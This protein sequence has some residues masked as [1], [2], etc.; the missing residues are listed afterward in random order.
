VSQMRGQVAFFLNGK[1]HQV[2]GSTCFL[3]LSDYLRREN[4]L[5]GTKVVCAEG[6]CGAC[7]VLK[8]SPVFLATPKPHFEMVNS[9]IALVAQ[10]DGCVLLTVEALGEL[11]NL[12]P[13]Q[14]AM[15]ESHASQCGFCTPGFVVAMVDM[16]E[17][18]KG[19]CSEQE[20][21]NHL[22]GNLCRCTGYQSIIEAAKSQ[23]SD[24]Y[25][26]LRKKYL[27]KTVVE[28]LTKFCRKAL[29]VE[30]QE[31]V[32]LAP[33]SKSELISVI[34]KHPKAVMIAAGTDLG[35]QRNKH[36]RRP[37]VLISLHLIKE[38]YETKFLKDKV[39]VSARVTFSELR[40]SLLKKCPTVANFLDVFASPQIKN[41]ATLVGNVANGSPIADAPPFLFALNARIKVLSSKTEKL[42]EIP[43]VDFYLDYRKLKLKTGELIW[44]VS[45]DLPSKNE[46]LYLQKITQ[47]KDLD[48][49]CVNVGFWSKKSSKAK[50]SD[51]RLALGGVAATP[52]RLQKTEK[53][54]L[55]NQ[56]LEEA[57]KIA[58]S[59]IS[60]L[61]DLR[62][63]SAYRR[64]VVHNYLKDFLSKQV[65]L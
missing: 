1:L 28:T 9:C 32:L 23:S 61:S 49:S 33:C 55:K 64:L 30:S 27:G 14:K 44:S 15:Y 26:H 63:S 65:S 20:I 17:S 62:G 19:A 38:L 60:P 37:P 36:G 5:T 34:K 35:V 12:H 13:V 46:T 39:V 8:S 6:D 42:I 57:L 18:H 45:F 48:I 50:L 16:F 24:L 25:L 54:F 29:M 22:T 2:S 7:S 3:T 43:I 31:A 59:E 4:A 11:N 53:A 47:R 21:K 58:Q 52:V 40:K 41:V 51:L 56:N 10:M